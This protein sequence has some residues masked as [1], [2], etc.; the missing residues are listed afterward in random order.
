MS[1]I[2]KLLKLYVG[3]IPYYTYHDTLRRS[4]Y[5]MNLLDGEM[6]KKTFV[7]GDEIFIDRNGQLFEHVIEYLRTGSLES[8]EDDIKSLNKLREEAEYYQL[9]DLIDAINGLVEGIPVIENTM[10]IG[11]KGPQESTVRILMDAIGEQSTLKLAFATQM[12]VDLYKVHIHCN[13]R[14]QGLQKVDN[15]DKQI[16]L[17]KQWPLVLRQLAASMPFASLYVV[18]AMREKGL[19]VNRLKKD[20]ETSLP[21]ELQTTEAA[22][23]PLGPKTRKAHLRFT[24]KRC[25]G[26]FDIEYYRSQMAMSFKFKNNLHIRKILGQIERNIILNIEEKDATLNPF[27]PELSETTIDK[28]PEFLEGII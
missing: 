19:N 23:L 13:G 6:K 14:I 15:L 7:N 9:K 8:I 27:I 10:L 26:Y 21:V 2:D 17:G 20:T 4:P 5:F 12:R 18:E 24:E 25:K 1:K 16:G 22:S 11:S 28:L 3:G